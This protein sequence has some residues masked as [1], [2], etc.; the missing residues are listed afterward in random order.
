MD[1][2]HKGDHAKKERKQQEETRKGVEN[3]SRRCEEGQKTARQKREGE[4]DNT[5]GGKT[6]RG[7][8]TRRATNDSKGGLTTLTSCADT[9]ERAKTVVFRW[10][11]EAGHEIVSLFQVERGD[12]NTHS[13]AYG[14]RKGDRI[15]GDW[16]S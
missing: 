5:Q 16:I 11:Q 12:L 9:S 1:E 4:G 10:E 6:R 2:K 7:G 8:G 14:E 13:D 3:T 15:W